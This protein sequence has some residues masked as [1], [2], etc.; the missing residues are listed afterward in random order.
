M[1]REPGDKVGEWTLLEYVPGTPKKAVPR[2]DPAWRCRCSCGTVRVVRAANINLGVS[3]SCG[4]TKAS[5][6]SS[7]M[8]TAFDK[9]MLSVSAKLNREYELD[10]IRQA[11][12]LKR[13]SEGRVHILTVR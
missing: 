8:Q 2:I 5:L 4:H 3:R 10:R 1:K 7:V 12:D 11:S 6:H 13:R 9:E